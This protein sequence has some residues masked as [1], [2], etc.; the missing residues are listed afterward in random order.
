MSTTEKV[1]LSLPAELFEAV[2]QS[3]Q[4]NDS[5]RSQEVAGLIRTGLTA[6]SQIDRLYPA[7]TL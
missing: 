1:S 6:R 2:S 3:A 4:K 5:N 7:I